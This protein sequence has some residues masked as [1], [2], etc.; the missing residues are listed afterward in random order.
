MIKKGVKTML[1]GGLLLVGAIAIP[2]AVMVPSLSSEGPSGEQFVVPGVGVLDV[3]APGRFYL[4]HEY[5]SSFEGKR[6]SSGNRKAD[7]ANIVAKQD[8]GEVMNFV[9]DE[10]TSFS[11]GNRSKQS[12]GY[13][14]VTE[15]GPVIFEVSGLDDELIFSASRYELFKTLRKI[16]LSVITGAVC[17]VAGIGFLIWGIVK[18]VNAG[19]RERLLANQPPP[20]G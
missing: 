2:V 20:L 12:L 6:Y 4:W 16:G 9:V 17:G 5:K 8:G 10:S 13:I 18:L 14:D 7:G 11:L 15:V 19:R 3:D 1:V